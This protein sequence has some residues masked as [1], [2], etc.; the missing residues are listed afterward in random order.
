MC[1][2]EE[3]CFDGRVDFAC[4]PDEEAGISQSQEASDLVAA[5]RTIFESGGDLSISADSENTSACRP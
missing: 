4:Q 5:A 2:S 3:R 1:I